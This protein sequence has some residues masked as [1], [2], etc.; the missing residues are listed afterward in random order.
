MMF[1][2]P[3]N[4]HPHGDKFSFAKKFPPMRIR[5]N[6]HAERNLQGCGGKFTDN[7]LNL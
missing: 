1:T 5:E 2:T 6:G 7:Q 3:S 4:F